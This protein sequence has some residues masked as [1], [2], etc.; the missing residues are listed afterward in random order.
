MGINLALSTFDFQ[1]QNILKT[2]F[3][4]DTG[5]DVSII[6][7]NL[8]ENS[9]L[10]PCQ[11]ELAGVNGTIKALGKILLHIVIN[12]KFYKQ[13]FI[14]VSSDFPLNINGILGRDFLKI[15]KIILNYKTNTFTIDDMTLPFD[16]L[17]KTTLGICMIQK[18]VRDDKI[19]KLLEQS[20]P[21]LPNHIT[22]QLRDLLAEY[23]H[24]F[25][26]ETEPIPA[27][28]FYEQDIKLTTTTPVYVRQYRLPQVHK[29][30]IRDQVR[31]LYSQG[32]LQ[33]SHSD[34]NNPNLIVPKKNGK[35]RMVTDFRQLNKVLVKDRYPLPRFEDIFDGMRCGPKSEFNPKYFSIFDLVKGFYQIPLTENA[36]KYTAFSTEDGQHEYTRMPQG[37][38][39][40]PNSFS[41]MMAQAFRSL[42][43]RG[44]NLFMDDIV[45]KSS[46]VEEHLSLLKSFFGIC[47]DKNLS[48]NPEK[49]KFFESKV[50]YLGH[51]LSGDGIYPNEIK[52]EAIKRY[53]K[54]MN[55]DEV[56]RFVSFASY[57]RKFVPNFADIAFPLNQ[58][59]KKRVDFEWSEHC[60]K[61]FELLKEKLISPP[62]LVYPNFNKP[63]V[64]ST[65][66]SNVALGAMIG[67]EYN[68]IIKP[69]HYASIS[70]T[71]GD[72]NKSTIE[73]ELAGIYWAVRYYKPYIFGT[74]F[75]LLTDHK[76][77]VYLFSLRDPTSKLNRMR[78]ELEEYDFEII[79]IK[80]KD[81]VV[82][83]ALSRIDIKDLKTKHATVLAVT[84]R[85][86]KA[87]AINKTN[88][89]NDN[90]QNNLIKYNNTNDDNKA[91]NSDRG[92]LSHTK[93]RPKETSLARGSGSLKILEIPDLAGRK[94]PEIVTDP[95][96]GNVIVGYSLRSKAPK[97]KFQ[98]KID[99]LLNKTGK[100]LGAALQQFF[101]NFVKEASKYGLRNFRINYNDEI[102]NMIK[103][104]DM[105]A[106]AAEV[107]KDNKINKSINM[108]AYKAPINVNDK[109]EQIEI[110]ELFHENPLYGGHNG[111]NKLL[112]KIRTK[113]KWKGMAKAVS[114]YI[115]NCEKCQ[116]NKP[117]KQN[118]EELCI[119][120]TP[121]RAFDIVSIDTVGPL[122][123]SAEG[124]LYLLTI[125]CNLTK[126]VVAEPMVDKS[127]VSVAKAIFDG[128]VYMHGV[129]RCLVSDKGTEFCNSVI[130]ELLTLCNIKHNTAVG[131]RPQTIG[132]LERNHRTLNEYFRSYLNE[133]FT[134]WPGMVKC[135][136]FSYNTTPNYA[137]SM[138]TPY[139][140]VYGK[141]PNLPDF[142]T[143]T[144]M[145]PVYDIDNY[146][147]TLKYNIQTA[148][149]R[150]R[151][152]LLKTKEARKTKFDL[153]AS[154]LD[155]DIGDRVKIKNHNRDSKFTPKF[156][157]PYLVEALNKPNVT[158]RSLKNPKKLITSHLN[159]VYRI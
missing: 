45:I 29:K 139:E 100:E 138:Y 23:I 130:T 34:Y 38:A 147:K 2:K 12:N 115:R 158:L 49:L 39:I 132:S 63:F 153:N 86:Q 83:D 80:G 17:N 82:A 94:Y 78:L 60:Q 91:D 140:L 10:V 52:F 118:I 61:S 131:Y 106:I 57:Y 122:P 24:V 26:T 143:A 3:L 73:K 36:R 7:E 110:I 114:N 14:V 15:Y 133:A 70:M 136:S 134:N 62:I 4:I 107:F 85:F 8:I 55:K 149:I 125:Q 5:S 16:N 145:D 28:N 128:F 93:T 99:Q 68:K 135:Y 137:I 108:Y 121:E 90:N 112:N 87:N 126:F 96:A 51:E 76:P 79:Y 148:Q 32:V 20:I 141:K 43:G 102:Y 152:F 64:I 50:T 111:Y 75:V 9:N 18:S 146:I 33:P 56:K 119:T 30:E 44:L 41:R 25:K 74:R 117:S 105:N 113:F 97:I 109:R 120:E 101:E 123:R 65:D 42:L 71:P 92:P 116:L 58:L 27:N 66:A 21:E 154:P 129:F 84:T 151:E 40:S 54:P 31:M 156:V 22:E 59:T 103:E 127:A 81:N 150:A 144:T 47:S 11:L 104:N 13:E 72:M 35:F 48:I 95:G 88:T 155:L 53:P 67:Q 19:L 37:L 159:H 124:F 98:I 89:A 69:V 1:N 6:N 77:L 157:G 46:T 142:M